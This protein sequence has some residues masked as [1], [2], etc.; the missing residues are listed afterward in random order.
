MRFSLLAL[1]FWGIFAPALAQPLP[2]P[3]ITDTVATTLV[4]S[5]SPNLRPANSRI[6]PE[7]WASIKV[8]EDTL[9]LLAYT[10]LN[11]SLEENRYLACRAIIPRL[12]SAL[13]HPYAF[14]YPFERL[15]YLSIQYPADSS[16]RIFT[17][18]LFVNKD[19]YRY[20]G[21]I[22]M[23]QKELQLNPLIDRSFEITDDDLAY[24]SLSPDR[25]YGYVVYDLRGFDTPQGRHYLLFGAD[26]YAAY[27]RRKIVDVL[28]FNAEGKPSFGLPIFAGKPDEEGQ[29]LPPQN[30]L[31][32]EYSA[33]SY[34]STR[35]EDSKQM[36]MLEHLIPTAGLYGEGI[37]N[38][39]DG[40]YVGYQLGQDGH[41]HYLPKVF[42]HI[43]PEN[44][45]PRE[46]RSE[47]AAKR[48]VFGRRVN[49]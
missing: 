9:G 15:Q 18:Q 13:K 10:L 1:L 44:E 30:R 3:T 14:D 7:D 17:W 45:Y 33:A 5:T 6:S 38:V 47:K 27:R 39:P 19:E 35:Y 34:V 32:Q 46:K 4:E 11:D 29:S 49:R 21:A 37:V 16:F 41:W 20:Y 2:L 8:I 31:I 22:Q 12:V 26:S 48:D 23:N 40:S 42:D 28:H 43:Y 24:A 36:I 25:W